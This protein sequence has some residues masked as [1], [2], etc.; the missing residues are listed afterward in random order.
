MR[1]LVGIGTLLMALGFILKG[2]ETQSVLSSA[3][4]LVGFGMLFFVWLYYGQ[5]KQMAIPNVHRDLPLVIVYGG[6]CVYSNRCI[7]NPMS[8]GSY[9]QLTC[10]SSVDFDLSG[11]K[12]KLAIADKDT[13]IFILDKNLNQ[14]I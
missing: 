4:A 14:V 10:G 13:R 9:H 7:D 1:W 6:Y 12:P 11:N 5:K 8:V 2:G 3:S